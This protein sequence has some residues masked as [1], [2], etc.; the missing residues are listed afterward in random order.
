MDSLAAKALR[1]I[2][3]HDTSA[4]DELMLSYARKSMEL[5]DIRSSQY[6]DHTRASDRSNDIVRRLA[7]QLTQ[8]DSSQ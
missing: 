5:E 1:Q 8:H 4:F 6:R 2:L 3:E 7:A